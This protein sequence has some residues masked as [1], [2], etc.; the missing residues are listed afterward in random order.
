[1]RLLAVAAVTIIALLGLATPAGAATITGKVHDDGDGTSLGTMHFRAGPGVANR[2]TVKPDESNDSFLIRERAERLRASGACDQVSRHAAVCPIT[3]S[4]DAVEIV[5]GGRADRVEVQRACGGRYYCSV[6]VAARG[7]AG[8]DVLTGGGKFYGG[9][10]HDVLRGAL[11]GKSWDR[12]HGGPG[13]DLMIGHGPAGNE[14]LADVF[15]DDETDTQAA[16]DVIRGGKDARA[17]L[18]YSMRERDL[19]I[20]LHDSELGPEGDRVSGVKGLIGGAGDDELIG[21]GGTNRFGG[22]PGDDDL[23]G[24]GGGDV[25]GGGAGDDTVLGGNGDDRLEEIYFQDERSSGGPSGTDR[26]VGGPGSDEM[27]SRDTD[28]ADGEISPDDVQ[29]DADDQPVE[30]DPADLLRDCARMFGWDAGT[31]K[32]EMETVPE[33]TD[34]GAVFTL[35]CAI[36]EIDQSSQP[37]V[38]R[39]RGELVLSDATGA[40]IGRQS[41]EFE[42]EGDIL[43]PWPWVTVTVPVSDAGRAAIEANEVIGVRV[44]AFSSNG[45]GFPPAGYRARLGAG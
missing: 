26:F 22:G 8:D 40:E 1:M 43:A 25:L 30:S 21:T 12:F 19:S 42:E 16:R 18:D 24:R 33:L 35:R 17:L 20:D 7:G 4:D 2:V 29:C 31:S 14:A 27:H 41:F 37:S 3:E 15:Y 39:C 11:R 13:G 45:F 44:N 5:L 28:E 36:T 23:D 32:F 38:R 6:D 9:R 34:E 10:G